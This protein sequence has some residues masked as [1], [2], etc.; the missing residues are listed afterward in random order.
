MCIRLPAGPVAGARMLKSRSMQAD[1]TGVGPRS[2]PPGRASLLWIAPLTD[3]SGYADEARGFLRALERQGFRP[4]A[5]EHRWRDS[6]ARTAATRP[7]DA[8]RAARAFEPRAPVVAVHH[9]IPGPTLNVVE[10]P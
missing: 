7:R 8:A 9:H 3:L 2:V 5:R 10:E 4:A 6:D 1:H